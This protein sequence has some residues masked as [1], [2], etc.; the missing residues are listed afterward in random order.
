[1]L[2]KI[3]IGQVPVMNFKREILP[4]AQLEKGWQPIYR[5]CQVSKIN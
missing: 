1:M 5:G 2:V 3:I 4:G